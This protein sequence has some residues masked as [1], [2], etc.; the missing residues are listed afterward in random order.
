MSIALDFLE[1]EKGWKEEEL[2][3]LFNQL[4]AIIQRKRPEIMEHYY[5]DF[6]NFRFT[7]FHRVLVNANNVLTELDKTLNDHG[8]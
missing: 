1:E 8:R 2:L 6:E 4:V 3:V 7:A 5:F